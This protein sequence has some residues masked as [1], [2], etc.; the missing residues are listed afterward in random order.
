MNE[1][2]SEQDT[3]IAL[4]PEFVNE[5]LGK[6]DRQRVQ[7]AAARDPHVA[8]Q[9]EVFRR[10]RHAVRESGDAD[11]ADELGWRR[12]QR[13]L[14]PREALP[15][16][17]TEQ[18][19]SSPLWRAAAAVLAAVVLGQAIMLSNAT[20]ERYVTAGETTAV[21]SASFTLQLAFQ[22]DVSE[23][24]LRALLLDAQGQIVAGPSALGLYEVQFADGAARDAALVLFRDR[25]DLVASA[26][27]P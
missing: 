17:T 2:T 11:T 20:G 10:I 4:I 26:T 8:A 16:E 3:L 27:V 14:P 12:L 1:T 24:A 13:A 23:Q 15:T 19:P 5:Q 7:Q 25:A 22:A 18:R 9:I 21:E 6:E